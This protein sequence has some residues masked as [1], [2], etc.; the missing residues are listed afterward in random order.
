MRATSR[1]FIRWA[2]VPAI[3][4]FLSKVTIKKYDT[5]L[6]M[7]GITVSINSNH[8]CHLKKMPQR[9]LCQTDGPSQSLL[10][11]EDAF[12]PATN[13]WRF[14]SGWSVIGPLSSNSRKSSACAH[15]QNSTPV[16]PSEPRLHHF[17]GVFADRLDSGPGVLD[18]ILCCK[19][20]CCN[21]R[22][23]QPWDYTG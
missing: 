12:F 17:P 20:S 11:P 4:S 5:Y 10:V 23:L 7:Q 13:N 16:S 19:C 9:L 3:A 8:F 2:N 14:F 1:A 21:R 15:L 22:L 6:Q 18:A